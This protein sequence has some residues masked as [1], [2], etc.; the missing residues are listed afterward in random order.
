VQLSRRSSAPSMKNLQELNPVP[1]AAA[2]RKTWKD[3]QEPSWRGGQCGWSNHPTPPRFPVRPQEDGRARGNPGK[4][5]A[6]GGKA[7]VGRSPNFQ[8]FMSRFFSRPEFAK[9]I[10][11]MPCRHQPGMSALAHTTAELDAARREEK[12]RAM[13][14][15]HRS[16]QTPP[17]QSNPFSKSS[18][19]VR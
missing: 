2:R 12:P 8:L 16:A 3:H 4:N 1:A 7:G 15:E 19:G 17:Q 10:D 11:R 9:M 13:R 5:E 6:T 14:E 18:A